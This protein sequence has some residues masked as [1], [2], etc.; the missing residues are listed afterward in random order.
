MR[1]INK[2]EVKKINEEPFLFRSK[3]DVRVLRV[4]LKSFSNI[5]PTH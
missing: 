2:D 1:I 3:E 5:W 4:E